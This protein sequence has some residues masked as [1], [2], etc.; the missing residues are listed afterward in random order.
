MPERLMYIISRDRTNF[1][2][3]LFS[4]CKLIDIR[5]VIVYSV[6]KVL[7]F[8]DNMLEMSDAKEKV[9]QNGRWIRGG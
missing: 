2:V 3:V 5:Q 8:Y 1:F 6:F 4:F 9:N 7:M